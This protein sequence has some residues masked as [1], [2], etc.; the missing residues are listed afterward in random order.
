MSDQPTLTKYS[1]GTKEWY[2]N[3]KRHRKDGPAY[4]GADGTKEWW[5]N[6]RLHRKDGPAY[7]GADGSKEW[8]LNGKEITGS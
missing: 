1:D 4:E 8:W 6:D 7:E 2:L 5:L 3:G